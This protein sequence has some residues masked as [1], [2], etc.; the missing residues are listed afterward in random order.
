MSYYKNIAIDL[1]NGEQEQNRLFDA[2]FA[3]TALGRKQR[4]QIVA[5]ELKKE[6]YFERIFI[7]VQL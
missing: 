4:S 3:T 7:P 1:K 2:D 5:E 6:S